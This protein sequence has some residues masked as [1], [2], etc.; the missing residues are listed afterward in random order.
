[1]NWTAKIGSVIVLRVFRLGQRGIQAKLPCVQC[2]VA[3]VVV[4][5]T[6]ELAAAGAGL[7]DDLSGGGVAVLGSVVRRQNRDLTGDVRR[8]SEVGLKADHAALVHEAFHRGGAV[9]QSLISAD[10][11]AIGLC[12]IGVSSASGGDAGKHEGYGSGRARRSGNDERE[13]L[14]RFRRD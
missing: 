12:V 6:M 2:P 7:N 13:I 5:R 3:D 9:Y 1:M 4:S 11:T 14:K 10:Q 8:H